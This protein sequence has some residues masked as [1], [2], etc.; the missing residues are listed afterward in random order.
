M[1]EY[2]DPREAGVRLIVFFGKTQDDL[3]GATAPAVGLTEDAVIDLLTGVQEI[4]FEYEQ[5]DV[6]VDTSARYVD[7]DI[8]GG[9]TVRQRVGEDPTQITVEGIC[10]KEEALRL[11]RLYQSDLVTFESFRTGRITAQATSSSTNPIDSGGGVGYPSE[12]S[13]LSVLYEFSITLV[14]A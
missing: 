10:T 3:A 13:E 7:H 5:P 2:Y 8:I 12:N 1:S 11:D 9:R 14:E 6:S 4:E